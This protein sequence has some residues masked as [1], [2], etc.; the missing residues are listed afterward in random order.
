MAKF[1]LV[2]IITAGCMF[3]TR[4]TKDSFR[5]FNEKYE[6]DGNRFGFLTVLEKTVRMKAKLY[7]YESL[8]EIK[9]ED[10]GFFCVGTANATETLKFVGAFGLWFPINSN[11]VTNIRYCSI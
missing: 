9:Y 6:N 3:K 2:G 11:E 7:E 1:F 8:A 10:F 5:S 4:P